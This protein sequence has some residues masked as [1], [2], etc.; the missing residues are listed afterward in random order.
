MQSALPTSFDIDPSVN[1]SVMSANGSISSLD[2][3]VDAFKQALGQMQIVIDDEVAG[4][5][6]DKTVTK[7]IYV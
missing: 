5:F 6:I 7:L 3:M 2:S 1:A 4:A